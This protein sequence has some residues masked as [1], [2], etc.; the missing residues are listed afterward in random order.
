MGTLR[1]SG[2]FFT[3]NIKTAWSNLLLFLVRLPAW[4]KFPV[5][6]VIFCLY[7]ALIF[8]LYFFFSYIFTP[9]FKEWTDFFLFLVAISAA[10]VKFKR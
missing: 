8:K 9:V 4:I 5:R 10:I 7:I 3:M 6:F 1:A 2:M